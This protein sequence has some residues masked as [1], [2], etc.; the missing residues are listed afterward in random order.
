[1]KPRHDLFYDRRYGLRD[2]VVITIGGVVIAIFALLVTAVVVASDWHGQ[3][4]ACRQLHEQTGYA[5][6][7]VGDWSVGECYVQ[8]DE[9][10]IPATRYRMVEVGKP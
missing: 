10:W 5:T 7:M 2:W 8:V 4:I 3:H 1:M 9:R 6:R